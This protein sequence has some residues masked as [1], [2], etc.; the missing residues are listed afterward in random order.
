MI[1]MCDQVDELTYVSDEHDIDVLLSRGV[2][3][4]RW[5]LGHRC[6]FLLLHHPRM[7]LLWC[8]LHLWPPVTTSR[9]LLIW[10]CLFLVPW[11]L[12]AQLRVSVLQS[13][14]CTNTK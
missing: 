1:E 2:W 3:L 11:L 6:F 10:L 12:C 4:G 8:R 9:L 7:K 5:N 13:G 14:L